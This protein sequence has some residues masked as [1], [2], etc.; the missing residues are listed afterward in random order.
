[1]YLS[2]SWVKREKT[3]RDVAGRRQ[4][5]TRVMMPSLSTSHTGLWRLLWG[6][7][8]TLLGGQE[9]ASEEVGYKLREFKYLK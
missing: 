2:F 3:K 6:M 1:M 4:T 9:P 7:E 5:H 8:H